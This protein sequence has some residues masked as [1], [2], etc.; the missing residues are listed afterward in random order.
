MPKQTPEE[1]A[2]VPSEYDFVVEDD[3]VPEIRGTHVGSHSNLVPGM[4]V[5]LFTNESSE[6]DTLPWL[7]RAVEVFPDTGEFSAHWYQVN[8]VNLLASNG[9]L[10][11]TLC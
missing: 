6:D 4:D 10:L 3:I 8:H 7:A 9:I 2:V 5:C 1:A 11:G